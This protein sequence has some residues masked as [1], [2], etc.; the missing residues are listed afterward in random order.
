[1]VKR[2]GGGKYKERG[3]KATK[4]VRGAVPWWPR[5]WYCFLRNEG[6]PL[7]PVK[8]RAVQFVLPLLSNFPRSH[9]PLRVP[10]DSHTRPGVTLNSRRDI[11]DPL[12]MAKSPTESLHIQPTLSRSTT[13][14]SYPLSSEHR[15]FPRGQFYNAGRDC[16]WLFEQHRP[17]LRK[18]FISVFRVSFNPDPGWKVKWNYRVD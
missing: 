15:E 3:L 4:R 12:E 6:Q 18:D 13:L 14:F 9:A 8:I 11:F 7:W 1:M 5:V 16:A 17:L 2:G 10:R